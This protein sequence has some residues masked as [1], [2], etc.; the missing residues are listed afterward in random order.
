LELTNILKK[1]KLLL[2]QQ[3]KKMDLMQ[4]KLYGLPF[5][6]KA[7]FVI[8]LKIHLGGKKK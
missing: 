8:E 7:Q 1:E 4:I 2:G 6:L 5:I 3:Q